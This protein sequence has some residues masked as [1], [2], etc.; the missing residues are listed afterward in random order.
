M[1]RIEKIRIQEKDF[2]AK[3]PDDIGHRPLEVVNE[4]GDTIALFFDTSFLKLKSQDPMEYAREYDDLFIGAFKIFSNPENSDEI[5]EKWCRQHPAFDSS[6]WLDIN[7]LRKMIVALGRITYYEFQIYLYDTVNTYKRIFEEEMEGCNL[8]EFLELV[9]SLE[10]K[11][12]NT[13]LTNFFLVKPSQLA[14]DYFN[15]LEKN[16]PE[17]MIVYMTFNRGLKICMNEKDFLVNIPSFRYGGTPVKFPLEV[18]NEVGEKVALFWN[19]SYSKFM[20]R[21][22]LEFIKFFDEQFKYYDIWGKAAYL[23][24]GNI[25]YTED[26]V[27]EMEA[28]REEKFGEMEKQGFEITGFDVDDYDQKAMVALGRLAY[29]YHLRDYEDVVDAYCGLWGHY[30]F[31]DDYHRQS[32][33]NCNDPRVIA[34][35]INPPFLPQSLDKEKKQFIN[36]IIENDQIEE[37]YK[38]PE[39]FVSS[40]TYDIIFEI[41]NI[42]KNMQL[43][44][45]L[46][47][48][49]SKH[50]PADGDASQNIPHLKSQIPYIK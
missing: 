27:A 30:Y 28:E 35:F 46:L 31:P 44:A 12:L 48:Y 50:F 37:I 8:D 17:K 15:T 7:N 45:F 5:L 33:F 38:W 34:T 1:P 6:L 11:E 26:E 49:K 42:T 39:S 47:D 4:A 20:S 23:Y 2:P 36:F 41:A 21:D 16:Y 24:S 18:I 25:D 29:P 43:K 19:P 14:V 3:I 10:N 22:P 40:E 32:V 9:F 13:Q